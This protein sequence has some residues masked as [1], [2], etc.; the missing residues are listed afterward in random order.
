MRIRQTFND[1]VDKFIYQF[2]SV[3]RNVEK[4]EGLREFQGEDKKLMK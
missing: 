4:S 2:G 3:F 1:H